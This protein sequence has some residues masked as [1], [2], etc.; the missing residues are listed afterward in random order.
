M[1]FERGWVK[2][3]S[4]E[5]ELLVLCPHLE[6]NINFTTAAGYLWGHVLFFSPPP[7]TE[8]PDNFMNVEICWCLGDN[9]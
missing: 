8:R 9:V 5:N 6:F 4:V 7:Q 1:K 2:L 3:Y